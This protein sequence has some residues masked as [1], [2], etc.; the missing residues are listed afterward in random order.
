M[1][2]AEKGARV[3]LGV[4]AYDP[5]TRRRITRAALLLEQGSTKIRSIAFRA[6]EESQTG[7]QVLSIVCADYA[8]L[9]DRKQTDA[10][11]ARLLADANFPRRMRS[12]RCWA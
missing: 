7:A 9:G 6:L 8:G 1:R 5:R 4:L 10:A 3:Y 11:A 2:G 12:K